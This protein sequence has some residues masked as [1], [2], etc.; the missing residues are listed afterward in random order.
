PGAWLSSSA[1]SLAAGL[2]LMLVLLPAQPG[3]LFYEGLVTAG[4]GTGAFRNVR[5]SLICVGCAHRHLG[6]EAQRRCHRSEAEGHVTGLLAEDGRI[7]RFVRSSEA[8]TL[9]RDPQRRGEQVEIS[10][11][12][13]DHID[14]LRVYAVE[15]L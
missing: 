2:A 10:A 11:R 3:A 14:Y 12:P 5:G 4:A 6:I 8:T 9:L 13:L 1:A 7:W 15:S